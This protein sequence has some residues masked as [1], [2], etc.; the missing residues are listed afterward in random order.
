MYTGIFTLDK[1]TQDILSPVHFSWYLNKCHFL[2]VVLCSGFK[3]YSCVKVLY[4]NKDNFETK[5]VYV[6]DKILQARLWSLWQIPCLSRTSI[7]GRNNMRT[8]PYYILLYRYSYAFYFL[9]TIDW[10]R[11]SR[12]GTRLF[13]NNIRFVWSS[14][15]ERK[16]FGPFSICSSGI[17]SHPPPPIQK[18]FKWKI[19]Q[20]FLDFFQC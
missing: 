20:P 19:L 12:G 7:F 10:N 5:I 13:H 1:F 4:L 18:Y 11:L 9:Y 8:A 14:L 16:K 15:K 6:Q 3:S 2:R 17:S